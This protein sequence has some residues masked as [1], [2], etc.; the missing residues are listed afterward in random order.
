MWSK[1]YDQRRLHQRHTGRTYGQ[2]ERQHT[3]A[4]LADALARCEKNG[5]FH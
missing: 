3:I 5:V 2:T 4:L 1:L